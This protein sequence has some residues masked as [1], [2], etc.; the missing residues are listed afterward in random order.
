[1]VDGV[2]SLRSERELCGRTDGEVESG[3][4]A[5]EDAIRQKTGADLLAWR[6]EQ[7]N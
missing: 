4:C 5:T 3:T 1:M 6:Q 7:A 2:E